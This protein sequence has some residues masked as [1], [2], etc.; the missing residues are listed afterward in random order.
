MAFGAL[1]RKLVVRT[2]SRHSAHSR[3]I[4]AGPPH[5]IHIRNA[6]MTDDAGQTELTDDLKTPP[7]SSTE[8]WY[9][10]LEA[11]DAQVDT[12][13]SALSIQSSCLL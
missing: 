3:K 12:V 8:S 7:A 10:M 11:L 4:I 5:Q 13:R 6:H 9:P 2:G 1:R